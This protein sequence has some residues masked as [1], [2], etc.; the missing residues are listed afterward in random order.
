VAKARR[1]TRVRRA[2]R[3][4][5]ARRAGS[6]PVA[7]SKALD[8]YYR[9]VVTLNLPAGKFLL[10]GKGE[11]RNQQTTS[12]VVSCNVR[13]A[14]GQLLDSSNVAMPAPSII[15]TQSFGTLVF[16]RA[17][18]LPK[19]TAVRVECAD[20]GGTSGI[21]ASVVLSALTAGSIAVQP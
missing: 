4:T 19:A 6:R 11:A 14:A 5:R 12:D 9:T 17:V 15:K 16:H 21:T 20:T 2:P 3:A 7:G 1:A 18:D 13:D 8:G 10:S